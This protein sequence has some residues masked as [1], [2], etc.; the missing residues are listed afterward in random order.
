MT[1]NPIHNPVTAGQ[2]CWMRFKAGFRLGWKEVTLGTVWRPTAGK[3]A[4]RSGLALEDAS[5][6]DGRAVRSGGGDGGV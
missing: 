3:G 4:W 2:L 6:S 1:C 5:L